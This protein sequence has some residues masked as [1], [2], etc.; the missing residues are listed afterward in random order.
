MA[1]IEQTYF[2]N[3]KEPL[4]QRQ[5]TGEKTLI[6]QTDY[7]ILEG[8]EKV[9]DTG[10]FVKSQDEH[11]LSV[12]VLHHGVEIIFQLEKE[13][14]NSPSAPLMVTRPNKLGFH[15]KIS[16]NPEISPSIRTPLPWA[17]EILP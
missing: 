11:T 6:F 12:A 1:I 4:F 16:Y 3:R 13:E 7:K 14:I 10:L 17:V 15:R 9:P 2:R 8:G 5:I